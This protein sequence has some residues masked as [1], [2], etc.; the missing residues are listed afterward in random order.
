M[1][2]KSRLLGP[3]MLGGEN[4]HQNSNSVGLVIFGGKSCSFNS[5]MSPRFTLTVL[6]P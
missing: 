1:D 2:E 3:R 5:T 4:C 6:K